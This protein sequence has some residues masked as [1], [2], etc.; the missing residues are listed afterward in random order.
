MKQKTK[1]KFIFITA[2]ILML[3]AI[4]AYFLSDD[5][6]DNPVLEQMENVDI[7]GK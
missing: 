5:E 4:C 1:K 2:V 3:V 7:P 6:A